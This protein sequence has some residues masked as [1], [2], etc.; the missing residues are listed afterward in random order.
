MLVFSRPNPNHAGCNRGA[1]YTGVN[2]EPCMRPT[3]S[4]RDGRDTLRLG[5]ALVH[6]GLQWNP[7]ELLG[8]GGRWF[9]QSL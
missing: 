8:F 4:E 5:G 3:R 7:Q 2:A 9:D 6:R 1:K